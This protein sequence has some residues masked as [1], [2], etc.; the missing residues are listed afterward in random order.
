MKPHHMVV[1]FR[2]SSPPLMRPRVAQYIQV[3]MLAPDLNK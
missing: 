2:L 1:H 3:L